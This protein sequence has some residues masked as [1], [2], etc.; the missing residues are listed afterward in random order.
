MRFRSTDHTVHIVP[1]NNETY[2]NLLKLISLTYSSAFFYFWALQIHV[3]PCTR[4]K[5]YSRPLLPQLE[6]LEGRRS[7]VSNFPYI[8]HCTVQIL[9]S[10]VILHW[11][12]Q[13]DLNLRYESHYHATKHHYQIPSYKSLSRIGQYNNTL[14]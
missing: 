2:C 4:D 8:T 9:D 1:E 11:R 6:L 12:Q 3:H 10:T 7:K 14:K 5:N 13:S